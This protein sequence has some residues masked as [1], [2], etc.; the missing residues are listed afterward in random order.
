MTIAIAIV[1]ATI[2]VVV[3]MVVDVGIVFVTGV[4]L[5]C[6]IAICFNCF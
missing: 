6:A 3:V 2:S 1:H 5:C 4:E